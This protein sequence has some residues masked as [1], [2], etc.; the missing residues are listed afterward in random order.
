MTTT[1]WWTST[2]TSG[3]KVLKSSL[4]PAA[5][6]GSVMKWKMSRSGSDAEATADLIATATGRKS[7]SSLQKQIWIR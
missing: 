3:R 1:L 6:S 5:E 7:R 2:C 4:A